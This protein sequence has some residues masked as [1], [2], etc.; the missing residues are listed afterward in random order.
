[1]LSLILNCLA[2][3]DRYLHC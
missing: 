2:E 1:M 3:A